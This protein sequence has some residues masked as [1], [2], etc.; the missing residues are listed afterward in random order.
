MLVETLLKFFAHL[1][2]MDAA[3]VL[4]RMSEDKPP[5]YQRWLTEELTNSLFRD[6]PGLWTGMVKV[7]LH[8][9][10]FLNLSQ[11]FLELFYKICMDKYYKKLHTLILQINITANRHGYKY[12]W[13]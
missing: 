5:D 4:F 2:A 11:H 8:H 7:F 13:P 12:A 6:G 9:H 1:S 3:T 10:T